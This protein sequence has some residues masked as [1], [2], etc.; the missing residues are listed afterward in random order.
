[1][2]TIHD[3][4][5]K[6]LELDEKRTPG[7]WQVMSGYLVRVCVG[8]VCAPIADIRTPYRKGVGIIRGERELHYNCQYIAAMPDACA[9][10][11]ELSRR[12]EVAEGDLRYVKHR[13]ARWCDDEVV[14]PALTQITAPYE[15]KE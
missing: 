11:R 2:T 14:T 9:L 10:L 15:R 12:L 6:L 13:D 1:M 8:D 7:A 3:E 5:K 4:A